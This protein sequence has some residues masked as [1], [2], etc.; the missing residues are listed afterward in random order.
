[1]GEVTVQVQKLANLGLSAPQ[2]SLA[3]MLVVIGFVTFYLLPLAFVFQNFSL[4]L[5]ILTGILMGMVLGLSLVSM[6]L[7]STLERALLWLCL[8]FTPDRRMRTVVRKNL[9]GHRDRN[10]KTAYMITI[11]VSFLLFSGTMFTL[12]TNSL[13][14]TV[15]MALGS[16]I[17]AVG[18]SSELA[19]P[20]VCGCGCCCG[21][22]PGSVHHHHQLTWRLY[23]CVF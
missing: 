3:I 1:M 19:L 15:S 6:S 20:Q 7:Q 21:V 11:S 16:D 23:V 17:F 4:F 10:R 9:T 18:F 12:Q 8:S 5:G 22:V 13:A 14:S 2:T